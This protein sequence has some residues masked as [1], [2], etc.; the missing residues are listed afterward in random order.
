MTDVVFRAVSDGRAN[1]CPFLRKTGSASFKP[2]SPVM[3][4]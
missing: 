2:R 1:A 3:I 4:R